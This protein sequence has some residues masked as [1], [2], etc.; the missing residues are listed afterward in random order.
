[1]ETTKDKLTAKQETLAQLKELGLM[2]FAAKLANATSPL[3]SITVET[4]T[5]NGNWTH[6][7][8]YRQD[9]QFEPL[10]YCNPVSLIRDR[11]L[12]Y[13]VTTKSGC[14]WAKKEQIAGNYVR[15]TLISEAKSPT[16]INSIIP[17]TGF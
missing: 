10:I 14:R 3:E 13:I 6:L 5:V 7:I 9:Y 1:M 2:D 17:F 16:R 15:R 4:R 8:G 12:A 11:S